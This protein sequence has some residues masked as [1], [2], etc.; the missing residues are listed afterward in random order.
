MQRNADFSNIIISAIAGENDELDIL[1][2]I[3][4]GGL[5]WK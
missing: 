2:K 4:W 1:D 3:V 5:L